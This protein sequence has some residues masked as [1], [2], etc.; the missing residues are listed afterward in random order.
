MQ[1]PCAN[2]RQHD[3]GRKASPDC[4]NY[5]TRRQHGRGYDEPVTG[6]GV[7]LASRRKLG[8]G[9]YRVDGLY[10]AECSMLAR[11]PDPSVRSLFTF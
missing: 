4:P 7:T 1:V 6:S 2:D 5:P 9:R 10:V 3:K 8:I 11:H